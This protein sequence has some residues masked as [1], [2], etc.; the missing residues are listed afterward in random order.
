M[1][2]LRIRG[3]INEEREWWRNK[4]K[5]LPLGIDPA[6]LKVGQRVTLSPNLSIYDRSYIDETFIVL[7]INSA[8]A[9]LYREKKRPYSSQD[10]IIMFHERH[11]YAADS[12]IPENGTPPT[13]TAI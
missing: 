6:D 12:F 1:D 7:A 5:D 11:I 2:F 9:Q 3:S 13:N 10:I 8:S 4:A